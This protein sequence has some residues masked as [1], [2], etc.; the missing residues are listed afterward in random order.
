MKIEKKAKGK[1]KGKAIIGIAMAAIMLA[2][3]IAVM[4]GGIGAIS[5]GGG[6]IAIEASTTSAVELETVILT[7]TGVAGDDIRV[8]S[9]PLSPH[10]IFKRGMY[11]TPVDATNWFNHTIDADG[12]RRYA[13][14]FNDTGTYT[15]RVTVTDSHGGGREGDY[16]DV[17]IMVSPI[18]VTFDMPALA[19]IGDRITIRGTANSGTYVSVWVDNVLYHKLVDLVIE[20]GEFSEEVTA[21]SGVGMGVPGTVRLK[22]WIDAA[23]EAGEAPPTGSPD[24][25]ER[26]FMAEPWLTAGLSPD[27]VE[28]EEDFTVSGSAPG[29]RQV[30][31]LCVPPKGGGGK[32]LLDKG[33]TGVALRKA[34]VSSVDNTFSRKFWVQE[35]ADSGLYYITVLSSGM[36][37]EWDMT[38]TSDLETA[39]DWRYRIPSLT[40]GIIHTKT[41]EDVVEILEDLT[42][43]AGSDD[44][45]RI[46]TLKVGWI[47]TLT[48][49][50]I[51]DVVAGE[52]LE[53]TGNS[54]RKDGS[55]IWIT[56]KKP[57]YEIA[58]QAAIVNDNTFSATFDT[59]GAQPGTYIVKAND[60][61]GYTAMASVNILAETP[62][63][64]TSFDTGEG[65][66]P[67]IM[68]THNGTITIQ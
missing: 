60:G 44:L 63:A 62:P 4:I 59:T 21:N 11:D 6:E 30:T 10:V 45:M 7:V 5:V 14:E 12:V 20:D 42:Q 58:P 17:D 32:S 64:P 37:D 47:E 68:G 25:S 43:C 55:L 46:L 23:K 1:A 61:Y 16:D 53:V 27:S 67:S 29:S 38:G 9:S 39:L 49:N 13:V 34:S 31:I 3:V 24:G 66:Y 28:Q 33:V 15:I 26:M 52:P 54:S 2:S 8:E 50:P 56:V 40:E 65:S 22:A 36:D 48:V 18:A 51:A 41:Q 35:D 57:Y 19:V